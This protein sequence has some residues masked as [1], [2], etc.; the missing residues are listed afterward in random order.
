[1]GFGDKFKNIFNLSEEEYFDDMDMDEN[2]RADDDYS[3][4]VRSGGFSFN[5]SRNESGDGKVVDMRSSVPASTPSS[6]AHVV[7]KKLDRYED[8]GNVADV[9]NEKRIVILNLETCP[10]DVSVRIIDFLSGVA[11]ANGGEMK[12]V[13]GR[14]Y[15][16]TPY[17]VPLTGELLDGF[18]HSGY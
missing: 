10:N 12:R 16:I 11:Y 3:K 5:R 2:E 7:F 15:I 1:M 14:A 13:A 6:K 8:V 4:D 18:E 9:L 17:N